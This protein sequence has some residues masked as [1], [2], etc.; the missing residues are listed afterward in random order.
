M[1]S[2][3]PWTHVTVASHCSSAMNECTP[4]NRS[5]E[6]CINEGVGFEMSCDKYYIKISLCVCVCVCEC[7][8][9]W[10]GGGTR[11]VTW[12]LCTYYTVY[13]ACVWSQADSTGELYTASWSGLG[14]RASAKADATPKQQL[15][16][17]KSGSS[18]SWSGRSR[19][20]AAEVDEIRQ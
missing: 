17:T 7:E 15:K 18:S 2:E 9:V 1:V 13:C 12:D 8:C 16:W 3:Y 5:C 14:Q 11:L 4:F 20:A 6:F 10:L 19:R